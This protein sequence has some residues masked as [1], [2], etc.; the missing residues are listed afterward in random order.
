MKP[1]IKLG[2]PKGFVEQRYAE[3][4]RQMKE[5]DWGSAIR[6]AKIEHLFFAIERHLSRAG[7][8][9]VSESYT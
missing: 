4:E 8:S 1:S 2:N 9:H 6:W 7:Y 5:R 3:E